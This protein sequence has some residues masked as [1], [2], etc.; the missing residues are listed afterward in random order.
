MIIS[1]A[2]G[3]RRV[4]SGTGVKIE[5]RLRETMMV[6]SETIRRVIQ[7]DLVFEP[8]SLSEGGNMGITRSLRP[9]H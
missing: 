5:K 6:T 1:R 2:S 7:I 9:F 8:W 4:S 3:G